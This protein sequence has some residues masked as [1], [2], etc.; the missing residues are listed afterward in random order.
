MK[1]KI[2]MIAAVLLTALQISAKQF[3]MPVGQFSKLSVDDSVNVVYVGGD[4]S[5]SRATYDGDA[6]YAH[7]FLITHKG[8]KLRIQVETAYVGDPELPTIYVYSDFLK[9]ASLSADATLTLKSVAPTSELSVSVMG[10]GTLIADGL[11]VTKIGAAIK[12]GNGT[13]SLSG[14]AQT[15]D[16][17]MVGN[18][19]IQADRLQAVTVNC[20]ILGQGSIGCW[21]DEH[22]KVRGIGNTKIY[23][24]GTPEIEKK[25][26]GK[27]FP[28]ETDE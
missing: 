11:K 12:S 13:I 22:L 3:T 21:P 23:Y 17:T 15:A 19:T 5:P 25:G 8:D 28:L 16:F 24:K 1:I 26:G 10:N 2:L 6:K 7:A 4:G 18:G 27:I 9:N 20:K 14:H